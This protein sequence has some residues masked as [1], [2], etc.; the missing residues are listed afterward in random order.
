L[1]SEFAVGDYVCYRTDE[2]R[3]GEFRIDSIGLVLQ[4]LS[5]SYTTWQ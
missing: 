4:V 2:G 5:V 3:I 1:R